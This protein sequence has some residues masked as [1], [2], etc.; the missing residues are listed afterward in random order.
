MTK[1]ELYVEMIS[2]QLFWLRPQTGLLLLMALD[3]LF[4]YLCA[5]SSML[6]FLVI[7]EGVSQKENRQKT[8][9][10]VRKLNAFVV[11]VAVA[12]IVVVSGISADKRRR[13]VFMKRKKQQKKK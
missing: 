4:V 3:V 2:S 10:L 12:V 7:V 13:F 8:D 5:G 1:I 9:T 6:L 11:V